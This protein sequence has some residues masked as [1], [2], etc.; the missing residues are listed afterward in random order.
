MAGNIPNMPVEQPSLAAV[1]S[2][3]MPETNR[4]LGE[5]STN[6]RV[7]SMLMA[8]SGFFSRMYSFFAG[9]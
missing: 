7:P 2:A 6:D 5:G 8:I 4:S 9:A 3:V 1:V